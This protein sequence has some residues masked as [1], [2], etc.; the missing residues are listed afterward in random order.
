MT[1]FFIGPFSASF[2]Y[3]NTVDSRFKLQMTG[4]ELQISDD[5]R[6]CYTNCATITAYNHFHNIVYGNMSVDVHCLEWM[7]VSCIKSSCPVTSP[8][9]NREIEF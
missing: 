3:F 8:Q 7:K 9:P 1:S 2:L 6:N 5:G 4:F